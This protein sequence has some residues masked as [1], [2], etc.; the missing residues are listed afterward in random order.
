M[1]SGSRRSSRP[2]GRPGGRRRGGSLDVRPDGRY[3][4]RSPLGPDRRSLRRRPIPRIRHGCGAGARI[5]GQGRAGPGRGARHGQGF[6]RLR[7]RRG[8]PGLQHCRSVR[9]HPAR[10]VPPSVPRGDRRRRRHGHGVVQRDRRD[11]EHRE[12]LAHDHRAAPRV[13]LQGLRGERLDRGRG[14]THSRSRGHARR[15]WQAR[16]RPSHRGT[17]RRTGQA[18][19]W[20]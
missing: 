9:S 1:G 6:R 20:R 5:S 11:P 18:R 14:A 17:D 12:S 13:G 19:P 2:R 3:R 8:R 10:G 15:R 16:A 7:W 4:P